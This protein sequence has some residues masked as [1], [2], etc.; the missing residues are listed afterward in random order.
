MV[1]EINK[2]KKQHESKSSEDKSLSA[3]SSDA[4]DDEEKKMFVEYNSALELRQPAADRTT[5]EVGI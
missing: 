1:S 5:Y 4:L 2:L 3:F